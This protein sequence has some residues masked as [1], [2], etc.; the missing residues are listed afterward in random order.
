MLIGDCLVEIVEVV[1]TENLLK[2]MAGFAGFV[3]EQ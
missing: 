2:K 3:V 1:G